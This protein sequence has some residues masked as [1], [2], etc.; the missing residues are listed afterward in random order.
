MRPLALAVLFTVLCGVAGTS[1]RRY[2]APTAARH[3]KGVTATLAAE[4]CLLYESGGKVNVCH[5]TQSARQ[6]YVL[7]RVSVQACVNGH[8]NHAEDFASASGDCGS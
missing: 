2:Q 1:A 7:L 4:E 3:D 5:A 6:P 8:A